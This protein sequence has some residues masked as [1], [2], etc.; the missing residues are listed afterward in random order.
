MT[1]ATVN[2]IEVINQRLNSQHTGVVAVP[3]DQLARERL[4]NASLHCDLLPRCRP[5]GTETVDNGLKNAAHRRAFCPFMGKCQP[6][7]G[8]LFGKQSRLWVK[9]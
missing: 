9:S 1:L 4:G 7:Y 5:G 6:T 8:R 3:I 2:R